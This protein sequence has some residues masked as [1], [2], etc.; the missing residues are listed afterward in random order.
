MIILLMGPPGAGKGTQGALLRHR[1]FKPIAR[2]IDAY[3]PGAAFPGPDNALLAGSRVFVPENL[4][5][6]T[7]E[8]VRSALDIAEL[9][10][11]DGGQVDS[12]LRHG[13]TPTLIAK[14]LDEHHDVLGFQACLWHSLFAIRE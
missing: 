7:P 3:Y 13:R 9:G 2:A 6:L 14:Q 8:Q 5:G 11:Q 12:D 4:V 1:V 10:Y